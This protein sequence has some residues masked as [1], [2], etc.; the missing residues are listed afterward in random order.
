VDRCVIVAVEK[1]RKPSLVKTVGMEREDAGRPQPA[2]DARP[3]TTS[4][5]WV[6]TSS[7]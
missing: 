7:A 2:K 3:A 6:S 1:K 4:P 5:S